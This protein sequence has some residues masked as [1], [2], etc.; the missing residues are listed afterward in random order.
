MVRCRLRSFQFGMAVSIAQEFNVPK[1][2]PSP[3]A[4]NSS[5]FI[6]MIPAPCFGLERNT[7]RLGLTILRIGSICLNPLS[8][9]DC[10]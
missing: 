2:C 5:D 8:R 7:F 4:A 6:I 3:A 9:F 10:R 1:V